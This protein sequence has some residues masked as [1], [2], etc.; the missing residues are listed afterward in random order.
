MNKV[1]FTL[2]PGRRKAYVIWLD[3]KEI[4]KVVHVWTTGGMSLWRGAHVSGLGFVSSF[5]RTRTETAEQIVAVERDL[6]HSMQEHLHDQEVT[7][8]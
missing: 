2:I 7:A 3:G 6:L 4:G 8:P 5:N 1:S